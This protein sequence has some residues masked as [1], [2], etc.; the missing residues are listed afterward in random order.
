MKIY[1]RVTHIGHN[2]LEFIVLSSN[3][4]DKISCYENT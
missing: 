2:N 1:F 3:F 4:G